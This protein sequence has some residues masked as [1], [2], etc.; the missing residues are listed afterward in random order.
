M[1]RLAFIV[2]ETWPLHVTR[3]NIVVNLEY[4]ELLTDVQ[5]KTSPRAGHVLHITHY[6]HLPERQSQRL[7]NVHGTSILE[8]A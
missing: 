4:M 2:Y 7:D 1:Y 3:N 8:Y 6:V 5:L